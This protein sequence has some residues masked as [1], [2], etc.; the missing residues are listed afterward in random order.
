MSNVYSLEILM[1]TFSLYKIHI[2]EIK[3]LR[4]LQILHHQHCSP[5]SPS[6]IF[7][8]IAPHLDAGIDNNSVCWGSENTG[9]HQHAV[10]LVCWRRISIIVVQFKV[11]RLFWIFWQKTL[12]L[13]RCIQ[14]LEIWD[15]IIYFYKLLKCAFHLSLYAI[16][17]ESGSCIFIIFSFLL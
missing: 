1:K 17:L 12:V 2:L 11:T 8:Q 15:T 13:A 7:V 6:L 14:T 5:V 4:Q 9:S 3:P 16:L 10:M